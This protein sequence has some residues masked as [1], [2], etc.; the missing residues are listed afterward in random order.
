MNGR[1]GL[2]RHPLRDVVAAALAK[3]PERRPSATEIL[4]SMLGDR[5]AAAARRTRQD[6]VDQQQGDP[7]KVDY[8][9]LLE[10][11]SAVAFSPD[12]RTLATGGTDDAV[13]LWQ[14]PL[15]APSR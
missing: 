10:E 7:Q 4:L 5:R 15:A 11:S 9:A 6:Q 13:W 2:Q 14:V 8:G 12:G 1:D 3:Q